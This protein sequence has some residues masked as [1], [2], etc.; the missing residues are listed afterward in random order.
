MAAILDVL[1]VI[2]SLATWIIII[3]AVM[4]W[5]VGFNVLSIHNPTVRSIW[6]GL[7]TITEPFYRPIRNL[8]PPMGGFDLSPL[9]VLLIIFFLRS[10]IVRYGYA[11]VPF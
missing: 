7:Q 11:M 8:L 3:Q 10:L 4:S 9:V 2:L 5:L 6:G 1:L